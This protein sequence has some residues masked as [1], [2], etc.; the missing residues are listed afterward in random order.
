MTFQTRSSCS[1]EAACPDTEM[2]EESGPDPASPV[3]PGLLKALDAIYRHYDQT[4]SGSGLACHAGCA[5]CCTRNVTLTSIEAWYI[6]VGCAN[7]PGFI[8]SRLS[9]AMNALRFIP[10]LTTNRLAELCQAGQDIPEEELPQSGLPCPFLENDRCL[11]YTVRPFACRC[12]TSV[13]PCS[14]T[15]F[16]DQTDWMV[17]LNTLYLQV[18]EHLDNSGWSGNLID[19]VHILN[20]HPGDLKQSMPL[21]VK[22]RPLGTVFIPPGYRGRM[23]PVFQELW[24][25]IS[26]AIPGRC[27]P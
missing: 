9:G 6:L 13:T 7:Q 16:A 19:L 12:M 24:A 25:I 1:S 22:N 5:T 10:V 11:I 2:P 14:T 15:G 8:H 26:P 18:I 4:G 17:S 23:S 21:L 20:M 3:R 27:H